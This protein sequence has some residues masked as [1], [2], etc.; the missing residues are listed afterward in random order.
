MKF[1]RYNLWQ[2]KRRLSPAAVFRRALWQKLEASWNQR[3]LPNFSWYQ[4]KLMRLGSVAMAG[5]MLAGSFGTSAYAYASSDVTDG[6]ILYPVKQTLEG[7]EEK[8][9]TT[10]EAKA[11][12][13][14]KQAGRREAEELVMGRRG[15]NIENVQ[16][17]LEQVEEKIID[18]EKRIA[19]STP[20]GKQLREKILAR[21]LQRRARLVERAAQL[22]AD[23]E[24]FNDVTSTV[25]A[26]SGLVSSTHTNKPSALREHRREVVDQVHNRVIELEQKIERID[27]VFPPENS[28][29]GATNSP[30]GQRL[31]RAKERLENRIERLRTRI[32]KE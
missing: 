26:V 7:V 16:N 10:P 27:R 11:R 29:V 9:Q 14:L 22:N 31:E 13:Y 24:E 19:T 25:A 2:A 28:E 30:R 5:V 17:K 3:H 15:K 32:P 8:L 23:L 1:L 4:T 18:V 20:A 12:F 6:T 21:V